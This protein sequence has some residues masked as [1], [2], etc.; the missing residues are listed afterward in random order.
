MYWKS[1]TN[2]GLSLNSKLVEFTKYELMITK[3]YIFE[4]SKRRHYTWTRQ[5]NSQISVRL[6]ISEAML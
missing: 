5:T 2:N 3:Q 1:R 4:V 6:Y